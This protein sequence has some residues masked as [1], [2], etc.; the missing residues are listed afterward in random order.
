[1]NK[2]LEKKVKELRKIYPLAQIKISQKKNDDSEFNS[3]VASIINEGVELVFIEIPFI[4]SE[5]NS[6]EKFT[7]LAELGIGSC[8]EYLGI[9]EGSSEP[10]S[11]ENQNQSKRKIIKTIVEKPKPKQEETKKPEETNK[12]SE[13]KKQSKENIENKTEEIKEKETEN[14]TKNYNVAE[15]FGSNRRNIKK[16]IEEEIKE[17]EDT[18][19]D[20]E[21]NENDDENIDESDNYMYD[22]SEDKNYDEEKDSEDIEDEEDLNKEDDNDKNIKDSTFKENETDENSVS[23]GRNMKNKSNMIEEEGKEVVTV[24]TLTSRMARRMKPENIIEYGETEF[25]CS[26]KQ[27]Y[28]E[29]FG[30]IVDYSGFRGE[31][32]YKLSSENRGSIEWIASQTKPIPSRN[33]TKEDI[34]SAKIALEF[35]KRDVGIKVI[36]ARA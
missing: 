16:E 14:I 24:S 32:I 9:G 1:M 2:E 22:D 23:K 11:S 8:I 15:V 12:T 29:A 10:D 35:L 19:E 17:S 28:R 5:Y 25:L 7:E 20:I 33:L 3:F 36:H 31:S 13:T 18:D 21:E 30:H 26:L 34:D 27:P 4:K 6:Q